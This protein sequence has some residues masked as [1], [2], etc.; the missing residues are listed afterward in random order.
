MAKEIKLS[1]TRI[2]MFLECKLKYWFN[3]HDHLPKMMNPAFKLGIACHEVLESAGHIWQEKEEFS[4]EDRKDLMEL[5]DEISVREGLGDYGIH[6]I[7]KEIVNS[8]LDNFWIDIGRK[9]I[10]IEEKFGTAD[11]DDVFTDEGVPLIGAMD[12]VTEV[13][14]D[15][16]LVVDYKTSANTPTTDKLKH[17]PQLSI[18]D[19]VASIKWPQYK[20][21]ILRLDF[22]KSSPMDT[23]RTPEER[24]EFS[25]YLSKLHKGMCELQKRDA[26]PSLNVFCSW[27]D[28]K[29]YCKSYKK[30][31]EKGNY[32]FEA[33]EKYN[34]SKLINEWTRVRDTKKILE[35]RERELA[36]FLMERIR[37][38]GKDIVDDGETALYVR[39][40]RR[41]EYDP[42]TVYENVPSKEF[43]KMVR[44][45]KAKVEKY[46]NKR[47]RVKDVITSKANYN[48]TSPFLASKKSKKEKKKDE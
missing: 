27:C 34:D 23:Y 22:L 45:N 42:K 31:Y 15:T 5:Y 6:L 28:F 18:Y 44:L 35:T 11:S 36:M 29:D 17:D 9:I 12:L 1:A 43:V 13:D 24:E 8:K 47:P 32:S 19:L 2:N 4:E 33:A 25:H 39:K 10:G 26:K 40:N 38:S 14:E 21:I 46:I 7:G 20:R 37:E 30:A 16:L 3:Y 41:V 48:F